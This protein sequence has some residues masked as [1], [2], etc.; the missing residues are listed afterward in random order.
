MS[1]LILPG[2]TPAAGTEQVQFLSDE[3]EDQGGW[4]DHGE[5]SHEFEPA[6][7]I[8]LHENDFE[9]DPTLVG[10]QAKSKGDVG[11]LEERW[12]HWTIGINWRPVWHQKLPPWHLGIAWKNDPVGILSPMMQARTCP[13]CGAY[14][15]YAVDPQTILENPHAPTRV[16][17]C[18]PRLP[19]RG[20]PKAIR[21]G[22]PTDW[23]YC[24]GLDW[25]GEQNHGIA[26]EQFQAAAAERLATLEDDSRLYDEMTTTYDDEG[27]PHPIRDGQAV[28]AQTGPKAPAVTS[29]PATKIDAGDPPGPQPQTA[30]QPIGVSDG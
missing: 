19:C 9:F 18:R 11:Y 6:L 17:A 3:M 2:K 29:Q 30:P 22:F 27:N 20:R 21:N 10:D 15:Y 1:Q 16:P 5:Y 23:L 24:G 8:I 26:R 7:G 25:W 4:I 12:S 14:G 28:P 13:N